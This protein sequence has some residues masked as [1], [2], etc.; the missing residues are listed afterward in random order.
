MK[1]IQ[2][3]DSA[4]VEIVVSEDQLAIALV[5]EEGESFPAVFSTPSLLA[6]ME[7]AAAKVLR[8]ILEPG[9]LSVG[10]RIE[11]EHVAP[12]PMGKSVTAHATFLEKEGPLYLFEVWAEDAAGVI[13]RGRHARAVVPKAAVESRAGK[14]FTQT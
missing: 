14:R 1:E 7:R 5:G 3:R 10:A 2:S 12:T 11:L 6:Q 9:Q 13:G 4:S 8:P